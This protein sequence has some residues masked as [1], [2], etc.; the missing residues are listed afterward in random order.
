[1]PLTRPVTDNARALPV[2]GVGEDGELAGP[3]LFVLASANT[4]V[5]QVGPVRGG[6]YIWACEASAWGGATA[7]LQQLGQD[8][9]T[10]RPVRNAANTADLT[11]TANGT[12]GVG[13]GQ[14]ATMRVVLSGG[15]TTGFYSNLS[16]LS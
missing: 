8:G 4:V 6:D 5:S 3:R 10:F 12:I 14:G 16:G 2:I 7:T 13:V 9:V 11:M 15:P 1:M